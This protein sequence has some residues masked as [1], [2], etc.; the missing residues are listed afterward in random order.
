MKKNR[1]IMWLVLGSMV[2]GAVVAGKWWLGQRNNTQVSAESALT[3]ARQAISEQRWG[4][5]LMQYK[6]AYKLPYTTADQL[7]MARAWMECPVP[8]GQHLEMA[9]SAARKVIADPKLGPSATALLA[10]LALQTNRNSDSLLW[11]TRHWEAQPDAASAVLNLRIL[12]SLNKNDEARNFLTRLPPSVAD[13]PA[14]KIW[15]DYLNAPAAALTPPAATDDPLLVYSYYWLWQRQ[16]QNDRAT[17]WVTEH[18]A[19]PLP[20]MLRRSAMIHNY[21]LGRHDAVLALWQHRPPGDVDGGM[22]FTAALALAQLGRGSEIAQVAALVG[23]SGDPALGALWQELIVAVTSTPRDAL[24]VARA[25]ERLATVAPAL[26]PLA[27]V[28]AEALLALDEPWSALRWSDRAATLAP[29]WTQARNLLALTLVASGDEA[30]AGMIPNINETGAT[31]APVQSPTATRPAV[32]CPL[33]ADPGRKLDDLSRVQLL[34]LAQCFVHRADEARQADV[35]ARIKSQ[36]PPDATTWRLLQAQLLLNQKSDPKASARAAILLHE[37]IVIAPRHA[38]GHMFLAV[39]AQRSGDRDTAGAHWLKAVTLRPGLTPVALGLALGLRQDGVWPHTISLVNH[40][41]TLTALEL[42]SI[43]P[44]DR[45]DETAAL[46][47]R[48]WTLAA[49]ADGQKDW[50]LAE[51]ALRRIYE[52]DPKQYLAA[53]NLADGIL[54]HQGDG[55]EAYRWA[56]I[57]LKLRPDDAALKTLAQRAYEAS[58]QGRR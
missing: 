28:R 40:F 5:A 3:A 36:S 57:A 1:L 25:A 35:I 38:V 43:P 9:I 2:L 44:A 11:G 24:R 12:L 48:F 23:A 56:Q 31:S 27:Y 13:H 53:K 19:L 15:Q 34:A 46:Q 30:V 50:P 7:A 39:A 45:P 18:A 8:A 16:G 4:A 10:D 33:C 14:V 6:R 22:A 47:R 26:A 52:L 32:T 58:V 54:Q 42:K 51:I 41:Q 29:W 49:W 37:V 55:K 20:T 21:T 17:A